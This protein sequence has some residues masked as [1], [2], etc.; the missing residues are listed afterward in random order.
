ME[1]DQRQVMIEMYLFLK[2]LQEF[3][4]STVGI[5]SLFACFHASHNPGWLVNAVA[6][7]MNSSKFASG[8][9]RL[10]LGVETKTHGNVF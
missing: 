5:C 1:N 9:G 10:S 6:L 4:V 3:L 2:Q 7:V 8:L